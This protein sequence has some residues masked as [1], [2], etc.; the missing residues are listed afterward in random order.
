ARGRRLDPD[1]EAR[2]L[3]QQVAAGDPGRKREALLGGGVVDSAFDLEQMSVEIGEADAI[4]DQGDSP[5]ER[6]RRRALSHNAHARTACLQTLAHA[7][8]V[9]ADGAP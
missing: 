2:E 9:R 7:P 4:P 3:P 8:K 6:A 5:R 1:H